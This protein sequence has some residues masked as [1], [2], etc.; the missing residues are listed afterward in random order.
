[1]TAITPMSRRCFL[2]ASTT[3]LGAFTLGFMSDTPAG[4]QEA[5]TK[6]E[7]VNSWL[8]I[9]PDNAVVMRLTRSEMGQGSATGLAQLLA[10]ELECDWERIRTEYVSPRE[11]L[12][13]GEVWGDF[14][15]G[16]SGSIRELHEPLRQAG[17]AARIMLISAAAEAWGVLEEECRA[18]GGIIRHSSTK[19]SVTYGAIATLAARRAGSWAE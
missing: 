15:T 1:M 17:A 9:H 11:N 13:R 19:R 8:V 18:A 5:V 12:A 2:K 4:A 14:Q 16:G 3:V 6:L 10:E 7:E